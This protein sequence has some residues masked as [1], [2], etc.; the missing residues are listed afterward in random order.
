MYVCMYMRV[1]TS[2]Y[3][4]P[5]YRYEYTPLDTF[6]YNPYEYSYEYTYE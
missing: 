6:E 2:T 1:C 4:Y 5:W 3:E